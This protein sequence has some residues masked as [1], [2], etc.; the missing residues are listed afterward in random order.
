MEKE[1]DF[2]GK[3]PRK[4]VRLYITGFFIIISIFTIKSVQAQVIDIDT[5]R[6]IPQPWYIKIIG[7]PSEEPKSIAPSINIISHQDIS[8]QGAVTLMDAMNFIP[9]GLTETRGRQV[10]QFLSVRGQKYPY[11]DYAI[12][13]V[14]QK[15]FEEL[16]Y[17]FPASDIAEIE[18]IRSS[19]A[20]L[21]GLSGLSGLIN[22]KTRE[23]EDFEARLETEYGSYNSLHT[24]VSAGSGGKRVSVAGGIGFNKTDGPEGKHAHEQMASLY[25]M[26]KW[27][28]TNKFNISTSLYYL[29]GE[30]ELRIAE[31]PA[32][33]R[34][35][36]MIQGF[37][38]YRAVLSNIKLSYVHGEKV[39]SELQLFFSHR[40]P[41]FYDE[42]KETT[43]NERDYEWGVN[44]LQ[45]VKLSSQ[46]ILR[47]GGLYNRWLA[48][49]GKRF[50]TGK[51]CDIETW[52]AVITD[53]HRIGQVTFDAGIR[54][55]RAY[56]N[57]YGAF[58][59]EGDGAQF[60]TVTPVENEWEPPIV[61]GTLGASW[62]AAGNFSLFLNS[63]V[64]QVKPRRGT[65]TELMTVPMNETRLKFDLGA[66]KR[67]GTSGKITAALFSV[68]Q[69][70]A[71]ALSGST[72]L[73][74]ET[75]IRR[76]L[77]VNRDQRQWGAEIDVLSPE[78]F[79]FM[80]PFAN[81]MAMKSKIDSEGQLVTDRENP[82][83]IAGG[84]IYMEKKGFDLNM[85]FKYV[86][87]FENDRFVAVADG[88]QP[89]GDFLTF[90]INGG[91]TT[92]WRFPVRFYLRMKNITNLKYSTVNGYP[93]YGRMLYG[94]IELTLRK[95]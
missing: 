74:E 2:H 53:E 79:G 7:R 9:G 57:D 91:Y 18:V 30:R 93:D 86:S 28:V 44:Y 60:K 56:L 64:G 49:N 41:L 61:N 51:R 23:Y 1:N 52:S 90:D 92:G 17:F 27:K 6:I 84:G 95:N 12:N 47:F 75:N 37:D 88:P 66:I 15:E 46:N 24:H 38:P 25:S 26:I 13:G 11:P 63:A 48:P 4:G 33:T 3:N 10:K 36:D 45:S 85:L 20:L 22:V 34:Y 42:V 81:I 29:D 8:K 68:L 94:G 71:I 70:D 31:P 76:E 54:W 65:L 87:A 19:A 78:L 55:T 77:Y 72:W 50:Y 58:S 21:T 14:W 80:R 62:D 59:I 83:V 16:P 69:D 32:D 73:D 40:N 43:S 35:R 82:S 89:L 67:F 39:S 5:V